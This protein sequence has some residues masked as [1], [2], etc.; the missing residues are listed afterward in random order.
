[1]N[2]LKLA[3]LYSIGC[4]VSG[5]NEK[6]KSYFQTPNPSRE[7]EKEISLMLRSLKPFR[8]YQV[9]TGR[10]GLKGLTFFAEEVVRAYW[11]GEGISGLAWG[12]SHTHN[13][14]VL[15]KVNSLR[16]EKDLEDEAV[17]K[18][19]GCAISFGEV[20]DVDSGKIRLL[21]HGLVFEGGKIDL[22]FDREKEVD[23][24]FVDSP[25]K[26]RL[27]SVHLNVAR[28]EISI[29]QAEH[30]AHSTLKSLSILG[31]VSKAKHLQRA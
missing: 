13:F 4:P 30:L 20:V 10:L 26:D 25:Q 12:P 2:G 28:E 8:K 3:C 27:V 22:V 7:L 11:L 23:I 17:N 14:S 19:L 9:I 21:S 5:V 18:L 16:T 31:M 24:G 1:M 29:E 15:G 6:L